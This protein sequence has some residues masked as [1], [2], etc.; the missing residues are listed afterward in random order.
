[1]VVMRVF[2][3][4]FFC[5]FFC[6][7]SE[8][9]WADMS[10]P[11]LNGGGDDQVAA[12]MGNLSIQ[13][14]QSLNPDD[15]K[16]ELEVV[17]EGTTSKL[18]ATTTWNALG[19]R[20]ELLDALSEMRFN[21]PS[22]IQAG[23][24]PFI[25]GLNGQP[26][27]NLVGQA[28]SGSGK[29]AA[30][31]LGFLQQ[32]TPDSNI[33]AV[34]L[35]HNQ[36]LCHQLEAEIKKLSS[37]MG[38]VKVR[39]VLK[40]T[41]FPKEE[42]KDQVIVGTPGV[43][44]EWAA[45][46]GKNFSLQKVKVFVLDEADAILSTGMKDQALRIKA[47]CPKHCQT[48]LFSATWPATVAKFADQM[49]LEPRKHIRL[50]A[51]EVVVEDIYQFFVKCGSDEEKYDVL[52]KMYGT[53][54][55]G[56]AIVFF[57]TRQGTIELAQKMT[58]DGLKVVELQGGAT[59]E[60][61]K[62]VM[63]DFRACK[64]NVLFSTDLAGRGI[65]IS[66]VSLVVNYDLPVKQDG[67]AD[68]EQYIHRIGRTGRFGKKGIAVSFVSDQN[69]LNVWNTIVRAPEMQRAKVVELPKGDELYDTLDK[70][71]QELAKT[72]SAK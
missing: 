50:R 58:K 66:T 21:S 63:D 29:T 35:A 34:V 12:A 24:L 26:K 45:K 3:C 40:G 25:L 18:R 65:D 16:L 56:Q 37:K 15:A 10:D 47:K 36:E 68:V 64:F 48:L 13:K 32:L 44:S 22:L 20:E 42:V 14:Q 49:V 27:Y 9:N 55:I 33:Q 54:T 53:L 30:F 59:N 28:K 71:Q 38:F 7:L 70:L 6:S 46:P 41:A 11:V 52:N 43:L 2:V 31:T 19:L 8:K 23:A 17:N 69:A 4:F 51:E 5:F 72:N 1:M 67:R 61:R 60:Q 62:S 57:K 39:L